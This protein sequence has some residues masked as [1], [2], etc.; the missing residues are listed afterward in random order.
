MKP[1]LALAM[2]AALAPH[3]AAEQPAPRKPHPA[4]AQ[5]AVA[6][7]RYESAFSGYRSFREE[8]LASWREANE[9]VARAGGH[10]GILRGAG[11][12]APVPGSPHGSA[13]K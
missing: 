3:A 7:F 1:F 5:A 8:P 13:P 10:A 4:D 2:S 11:R 12:N 9:E 6:P